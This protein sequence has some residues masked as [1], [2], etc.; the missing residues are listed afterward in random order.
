LRSKVLFGG[1]AG[2]RRLV[3]VEAVVGFLFVVVVLG[4]VIVEVFGFASAT[5]A[6]L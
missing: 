6:F 1:G 2:V 3:V 5:V 4:L